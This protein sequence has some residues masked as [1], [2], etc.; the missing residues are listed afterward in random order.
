M[1]FEGLLDDAYKLAGISNMARILFPSILSESSKKK[2]MKLKPEAR[3][4]ILKSAIDQID[5]RSVES[6]DALVRKDL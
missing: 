6:V 4:E 2:V 5:H 3:A 1:T